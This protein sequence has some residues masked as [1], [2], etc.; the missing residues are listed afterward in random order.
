MY[1][2]QELFWGPNHLFWGPNHGGP[3][4][5]WSGHT[6]GP[7][8]FNLKGKNAGKIDT[9]STRNQKFRT[10]PSHFW[11]FGR[12]TPS[13]GRR[14]SKMVPIDA[15]YPT[16]QKQMPSPTLY[17]LHKKSYSRISPRV[18]GHLLLRPLP[19][20]VGARGWH[21]SI[22]R[23]HISS[24]ETTFQVST[25]FRKKV[26]QEYLLLQC[27]FIPNPYL[28]PSCFSDFLIQRFWTSIL[29]LVRFLRPLP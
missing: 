23:T 15:Q 4:R 25:T 16:C 29:C 5:Q 12:S 22:R 13:E 26:I 9:N 14:S 28:N 7:S 1:G 17:D 2:A 8:S 24:I 6:S 27:A 10:S 11:G 18:F 21:Q 3:R 20:V 19:K